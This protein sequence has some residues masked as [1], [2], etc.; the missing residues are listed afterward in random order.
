MM[1]VL[2]EVMNVIDDIDS[3]TGHAKDRKANKRWDKFFTLHEMAA[4]G[5]RSKYQNVR[6]V[7]V[8]PKES[9]IFVQQDHSPSAG[10]IF[11]CKADDFT[12]C[13]DAGMNEDIYSCN[14]KSRDEKPYS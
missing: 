13:R 8:N 2:V 7:M 14:K 1:L 9:E 3:R 6:D 4:A 5:C 11:C 12:N 10:I